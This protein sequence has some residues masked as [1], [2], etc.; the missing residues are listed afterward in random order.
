MEI[1]ELYKI[2]LDYASI[3]RLKRTGERPSDG[4]SKL[5]ETSLGFSENERADSVRSDATATLTNDIGIECA[6]VWMEECA[7]SCVTFW[8]P[9]ECFFLGLGNSYGIVMDYHAAGNPVYL[10][11]VR[12]KVGIV[13][14]NLN[15]P[16]SKLCFRVMFGTGSLWFSPTGLRKVSS[17]EQASISKW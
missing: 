11:H 2:N 15:L 6:P 9:E 13:I 1:G 17:S 16:R 3:R 8:S 12:N 10:K 4:F 7:S 14:D 5:L